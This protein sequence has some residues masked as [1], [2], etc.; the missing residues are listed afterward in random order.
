MFLGG[1]EL[2][3]GKVILTKLFAGAAAKAVIGTAAQ[4]LLIKDAC[5]AIDFIGDCC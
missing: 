5:T 4:A 3:I 1:F 2:I